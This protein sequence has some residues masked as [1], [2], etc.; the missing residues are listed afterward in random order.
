LEKSSLF[1][2]EQEEK[3]EKILEIKKVEKQF[4]MAWQFITTS[5]N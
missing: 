5:L 4:L 3:Q 2:R 1:R